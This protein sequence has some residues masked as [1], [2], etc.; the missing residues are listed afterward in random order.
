MVYFPTVASGWRAKVGYA[1]EVDYGFA[2]TSTTYGW[3]GAVQELHGIIDKQPV[4]VY[5]M[6]GATSL[7][8][9][10][11]KGQRNVEFIITYIPQDISL[12]TDVITNIAAS[13]P[14]SHSFVIQDTD[15]SA[16]YTVTGALANTVTIQGRTGQPLM[17]TVDYWCQN[18]L[19]VLPSS[20]LFHA[21]TAVVPYYFATESVS[22]TGTAQPQALT[23][24]ATI[25]NNL[26]RVY[27]FGQDYVRTIPTLTRKAEGNI[28][29]TFVNF[30]DVTNETKVLA[31]AQADTSPTTY[32]D[33]DTP[34]TTASGL[35][36]QSIAILLT[37][38]GVNHTLTFTG[39]VLPKI[40]LDTKIDD[41]V[42]LSLDWTATG[43]T[44]A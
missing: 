7:P 8:A 17:V 33:P 26:K 1:A 29:A 39:A 24:T 40:D 4:L 2:P 18:I 31:S 43:L 16:V 25:T 22:F 9:Y 12:L 3:V 30:S 44:L 34:A 23:F 27:Q 37:G 42:A 10:L 6:D 20:T 21:D 32:T 36:Q 5:R 13:P 15:T 35:S 19:S 14:T 38:V 28:T 41:I 11:I